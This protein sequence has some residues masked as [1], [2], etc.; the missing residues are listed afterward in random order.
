MRLLSMKTE[1]NV[2]ERIGD[3]ILVIDDAPTILVVDDS[4]VSLAALSDLLV[5]PGYRVLAATD[6]PA[7]LRC[8]ALDPHPDLI[9]MDIRMPGMDGY[10]V[11][12][13]LRA[14]PETNH[15]PV[16]FLT[17]LGE[18]TDEAR[19]LALGAAD[20]MSK[21]ISA[22]LVLARV[23]T[24]LDAARARQMLHAHNARLEVEV[25]RRMSLASRALGW[26]R[27]PRWSGR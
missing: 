3:G 25:T 8:A 6:G 2:P 9:L 16:V 26:N 1:T 14:N 13:R 22:P 10:E 18:A 21:P 5:G 27:L 4:P 11:L 23:R 19:G 15:V 7:A 12:A 17:A 20:Y 24:Q